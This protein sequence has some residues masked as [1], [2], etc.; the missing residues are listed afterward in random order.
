MLNINC[1]LGKRC[2]QRWKQI[3]ELKKKEENISF[4]DE[5]MLYLNT[6]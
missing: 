6:H 4:Q 1:L 2:T 5:L 3:K